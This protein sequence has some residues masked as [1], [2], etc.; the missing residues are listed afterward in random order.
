MTGAKGDPGV[1]PSITASKTDQTTTL[2]ITDADGTRELAQILDGQGAGVT[3]IVQYYYRSTSGTTVPGSSVSWFTT[4]QTLTSTY[5]YLWSYFKVNFDDGTSVDT[6]AVL[7]GS[8]NE[9]LG[10]VIT[11]FMTTSSSTPPSNSESGWS[12]S[13]T[14][15]TAS[16]P[17]VWCHFRFAMYPYRSSSSH[18]LYSNVFK[19]KTY[20]S[21]GGQSGVILDYSN[22][23]NA[24]DTTQGDA[25]LS[26]IQLGIMPVIYTSNQYHQVL[27]AEP[28]ETCGMHYIRLY[29]AMTSCSSSLIL[30]SVDWRISG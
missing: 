2:T 15:P 1:S 29:Y 25:A 17:Y 30:S 18:Y 6:P 19:L 22:S 7:I 9:R 3:G 4:L 21:H 14:E 10:S 12:T 13:M 27:R 5:Q 26:A 16:A 20:E 28:Y 24:N 11:Y 8:Y 23:S